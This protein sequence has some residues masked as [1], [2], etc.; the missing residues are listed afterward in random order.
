MTPGAHRLHRQPVPI[1]SLDIPDDICL[2][3][4]SLG[5]DVETFLIASLRAVVAKMEETVK[6]AAASEQRTGPGRKPKGG[7]RA[8]VTLQLEEH[9]VLPGL[10]A[11]IKKSKAPWSRSDVVN[12][13]VKRWLTDEHGALP[14]K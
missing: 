5:L 13:L 2:R 3:A 7:G 14:Q 1:I 12:W 10:D 11:A 4:Q 9:D 8:Q 6:E